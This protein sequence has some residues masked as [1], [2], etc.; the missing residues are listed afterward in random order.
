MKVSKV[1]QREG[2]N[3]GV[4]AIMYCHQQVTHTSSKYMYCVHVC[5]V[6]V[7]SLPSFHQRAQLTLAHCHHLPPTHCFEFVRSLCLEVLNQPLHSVSAEVQCPCCYDTAQ[8]HHNSASTLVLNILGN[9]LIHC[10]ACSRD[11]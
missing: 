4:T 7:N 11:I 1:S 3:K 5:T 6:L 2:G 10:A 8:L 9:I